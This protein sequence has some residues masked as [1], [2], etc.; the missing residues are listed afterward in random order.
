MFPTIERVYV[1]ERARKELGWNPRY[2]F[3][4]ML[5]CLRAGIDR[6]SSLARAIGSKGYHTHQFEEGPYPVL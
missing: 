5:D 4:Y 1:N 6:R 2:D 3:R